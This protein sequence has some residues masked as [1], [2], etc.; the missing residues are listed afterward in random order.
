MRLPS[1][2]RRT[3]VTEPPGTAPA[4][5]GSNV[6]VLLLGDDRALSV[7]RAIEGRDHSPS[8][9]H[10]VAPALVGPMHW[11]ATADDDAHHE[12]EARVLATEWTLAGS[13]GVEGEAGDADPIQAVEDALQGFP[14]DEILIA[15]GPADSDLEAE[16]RRFGLPIT[17]LASAPA[18]RRSQ[19][20]R[21][22]RGLAGGHGAA[23]PFILFAGVNAAL[24]LAGIVLSLLVLL[25]LW[26]TGAL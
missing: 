20:Y 7:R 25:V 8:R 10:V 12:A 22:F 2:E 21:A 19:L 9:I 1:G 5:E 26:L 15:G 4:S 3:E 18:R 13:D 14:A 23:T 17:R 16:L 6:L 24:L 11:L